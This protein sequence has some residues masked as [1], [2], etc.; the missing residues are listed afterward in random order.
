MIWTN[1]GML[2]RWAPFFG[3]ARF[4]FLRGL[5]RCRRRKRGSQG[6]GFVVSEVDAIV[7]GVR[8]RKNCYFLLSNQS[9]EGF[10]CDSLIGRFPAGSKIYNF[11]PHLKSVKLL[12][13]RLI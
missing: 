3:A 1:R 4:P 5:S 8:K 12:I 9:I 13:I 7:G 6:D 2:L 10:L 11:G